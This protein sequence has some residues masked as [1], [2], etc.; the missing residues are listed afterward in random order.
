[1]N[2]NSVFRE[3]FVIVLGVLILIFLLGLILTWQPKFQSAIYLKTE[4]Y[5][6]IV[7]GLFSAYLAI[8]LAIESA[9]EIYLKVFI[10]SNSNG[11]DEA[12]N[13]GIKKDSKIK[14]N[15]SIASLI[16]GIAVSLAGVRF[17][18]PFFE[19]SSLSGFQLLLFHSLD[20][21]LT[22]GL[23]SGGSDGIH[24]ITSFY[25][26]QIAQIKPKQ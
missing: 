19:I 14:T 10:K 16:V 3:S 11:E 6:D 22:A 13:E 4:S 17:L 23:L 21:L 5:T 12:E 9:V 24:Q 15:A 2:K 8:S 7:I 25:R 20:I 26:Q 18:E 1:M